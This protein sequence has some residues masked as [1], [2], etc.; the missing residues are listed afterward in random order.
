M[1]HS[2]KC[3]NEEFIR[4]CREVG[5]FHEISKILKTDLTCIF[6]RRRRLEKKYNILLM[7]RSEKSPTMQLVI[8][9]NKVRL[10]LTI[11]NGCGIIGSDAH[12]W[13]GRKSTSHRAFVKAA[14]ELKPSFIIMNGDDFDGS[15][16]SRHPRIGWEKR[17]TQKEELEVLRERLE[18]IVK[19]APRAKKIRT[20]GNHDIR[21]DS[22]LA[23]LAPAVEGIPGMCLTDFLP[24]WIHGWSVMINENFQPYLRDPF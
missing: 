23:A 13:P 17:P 2:S 10:E 18:E 20:R 22:Y 8:P 4:L 7:P 1:A 21:Y 12:Y 9:D 3:S 24:D 19:A 6:R 15:N 14:K 5:N 11:K 16:L